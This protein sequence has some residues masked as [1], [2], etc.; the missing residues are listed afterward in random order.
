[1][2]KKKAPKTAFQTGNTAAKGKGPKQGRPTDAAVLYVAGKLQSA[3]CT[4]DGPKGD[5]ELSGHEAFTRQVT[6]GMCAT[7]TKGFPT[8]GA[9]HW[10]KLFASFAYAEVKPPAPKPGGGGANDPDKHNITPMV[11]S[12]IDALLKDQGDKL[13]SIDPVGQPEEIGSGGTP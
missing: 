9:Y 8:A 12:A 7:N 6:R 13:G 10:A 2:G 5:E 11:D 1:M 4:I 3:R